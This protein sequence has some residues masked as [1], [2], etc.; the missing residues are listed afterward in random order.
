MKPERIVNLAVLLLVMALAGP[1]AL[2]QTAQIHH[3]MPGSSG[4]H[5]SASSGTVLFST[6]GQTHSGF[7]R[8]YLARTEGGAPFAASVL[9]SVR[10]GVEAKIAEASAQQEVQE[11]GVETDLA[12]GLAEEPE[13][14]I[15]EAAL[16]TA[17]ALEANYPNPFNPETVL[18]FALPEAAQVTIAVYDVMGRR[19]AVLVDGAVAAGHHRVTFRAEGLP[20]GLYLVRMQAGSFAQTRRLTL[21]K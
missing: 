18:P 6:A 8:A 4:V 17:F 10:Q 9:A 15:H 7:F 5:V 14:V 16:P 2:A 21:V 20:S 19:V 1:A 11:D 3:L 13:A 12:E